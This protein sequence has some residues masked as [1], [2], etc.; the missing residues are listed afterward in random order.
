MRN[1]LR[2]CEVFLY[3]ARQT[4]R[5]ASLE[6]GIMAV[7]SKLRP[8]VVFLL[9]ATAA[10]ARDVP[11]Q[12]MVWPESGKPVL[13][14]SFAKFKGTSYAEN[15]RFY[16][17]NTAAENLWGKRIPSANF[18]LYLFD[19][20]NAR[21]GQGWISLTDVAPGETVNFRRP[22]KLLEIPSR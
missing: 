10:L 4:V 11:A 18:Y 20:N 5:K 21:V 19:K 1:G 6:M 3:S 16:I 8:I 14:F 12:V 7:T 22:W 9:L 2:Y 17:S 13:R 15:R